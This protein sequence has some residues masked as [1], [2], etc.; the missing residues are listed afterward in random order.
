MTP[1]ATRRFAYGQRCSWRT[2]LWVLRRRP[3]RFTAHC[4]GQ[5]GEQLHGPRC[6]GRA[7]HLLVERT[8]R[9]ATPS[10]TMINLIEELR[11]PDDVRAYVGVLERHGEDLEVSELIHDPPVNGLLA[12]KAVMTA[13]KCGRGEVILL[14]GPVDHCDGTAARLRLHRRPHDGTL[15]QPV[16]PLRRWRLRFYV[17]LHPV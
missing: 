6:E 16:P 1:P 15:L 14:I 4:R 10:A 17:W 9:T 5:I 2:Y 13:R 12:E 3:D 11:A 7:G 8:P